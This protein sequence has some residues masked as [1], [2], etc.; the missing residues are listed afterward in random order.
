MFARLC[1]AITVIMVVGC[2][3]TRTTLDSSHADEGSAARVV[4]FTAREFTRPY[5]EVTPDGHHFYFDV[6]GEIYRAPIEG[7]NAERMNLGDGWK[8]QP[9]LS[10][11][12][13]WLAFNRDHARA[14]G[15]WV[16]RIG[17]DERFMALSVDRIEQGSVHTIDEPIHI[18]NGGRDRLNLQTGLVEEVAAELPGLKGQ[19]RQSLDG[20]WAG[21]A[22]LDGERT[23][24][25]VVEIATGERR[26]T[27]CELDTTITTRPLATYAFIPGQPQVVLS[28]DGRFL[29][30]AFD[31]TEREI[32]VTAGVET[33]LAPMLVPRADNP[34]RVQIRHPA[35]AP[36]GSELA[37]TARGRIWRRSLGGRQEPL[38]PGAGEALMPAYAPDGKS[39]AFVALQDGVAS[40]RLM[41][42]ESR[43]VRTLSS[44]TRVGYAN[45]VW[46]PDGTKL[47]FVEVDQRGAGVRHD[48][49]GDAIVYL[50]LDGG[51]VF[52]I[53]KTMPTPNQTHLY[54]RVSWAPD[55]EGVYYTREKRSQGGGSIESIELLHQPLHGEPVVLLTMQPAIQAAIVSPSG[56]HVALQDR[57]GIA[58][59]PLPHPSDAPR[60]V[61]SIHLAEAR[62]LPR[63][64]VNG[65]DYVWWS[66]DEALWWSVQD[67]I[68][69]S[70]EWKYG[71]MAPSQRMARIVLP[72]RASQEYEVKVYSGARIITMTDAG[73]VEDGAI[74]TVGSTIAYAGP[75]SG[76][77][78]E[79]GN[80]PPVDISGKT[81]IPGLIDVHAH[82]AFGLDDLEAMSS[83]QLLAEVAYGVTTVFDPQVSTIKT[84]YLRDLSR[85]DEFVGPT[86]FG[87][88]SGLLGDRS[89]GA[90]ALIENAGD[91][92]G[93]VERQAKAGAPLVK[94][95]WRPSRQDRQWLVDAA[96]KF[97]VGIASD[98]NRTLPIQLGSVQDGYT[99]IE[100][101]L[102]LQPAP[103]RADVI[104][105]MKGSGASITPAVAIGG[106]VEEFL[107]RRTQPDMRTA[108]LVDSPGKLTSAQAA[109]ARRSTDLS[110][111]VVHARNALHEYADMLESGIRVS[112]GGHGKPPGLITHWEMWAL[113]LGGATPMNVLKAATVNGAYKLGMQDRIGA[114]AEGMD[115]DFV[116]L[117]ANPLD[118]IYNTLEIASVV[119]RGRVVQ[120]PEG[121]RPPLSWPS[122]VDWEA[123]KTW[124]LGVQR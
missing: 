16:Q 124:N 74:A 35:L 89:N 82:H 23:M 45:P 70:R 39:I 30:C 42:R 24:L 121:T 99:A 68:F 50:T 57:L 29:H 32:A 81:V 92:L 7:G 79:F 36:D 11:N 105:F 2:S 119:R 14:P 112:I 67:E 88:G 100:H 20:R 5:I 55:G 52:E 8:W 97:G 43:L 13:G 103:S 113:T 76:L 104:G 114:L 109:Q 90:H 111:I 80:S 46:S 10:M 64:A 77:P 12:G 44:S 83:R 60:N 107:A 48:A 47:A 96:R 49:A 72:E 6:L 117:D 56:R 59:V 19:F 27:G 71:R 63:I 116:I 41:D 102:T 87:S 108:C 115:A 18:H 69:A 51:R 98:E 54:Q 4:A 31:G 62:R 34:A 122:D 15:A 25:A 38:L 17:T 9:T 78:E 93:Y 37:F 94:A 65:P 85:D 58:I 61:R 86:F 28:R 106:N 1:A 120:W 73:V 118:D 3:V 40:L 101:G 66:R 110:G 95:Y 22:M 123:C 53:A 26:V 33:T 91:A 84:A 75:A 21:Y